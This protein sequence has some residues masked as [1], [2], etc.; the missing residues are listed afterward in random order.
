MMSDELRHWSEIRSHGKRHFI[1]QYGLRRFAL[2]VGIAVWLIAFV[3]I[4]I[5]FEDRA[6]PNFGYLRT[7]P[8]FLSIIAGL[9]LW[10][11]GGYI[12]AIWEWHRREKQYAR[13]RSA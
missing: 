7:R 10:P 13:R 9:V 6:T 2:R 8:F 5:F 12:W 1:I 11:I 3:V 4:P